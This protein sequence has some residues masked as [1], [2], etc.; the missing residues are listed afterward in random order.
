ME[1]DILCNKI[2]IS[3]FRFFHLLKKKHLSQKNEK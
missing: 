1:K 3:V 2:I